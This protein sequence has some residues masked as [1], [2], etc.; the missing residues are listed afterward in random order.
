MSDAPS[1]RLVLAAAPVEYELV[2]G[3]LDH[4]HG[5]GQLLQVDEPAPVHIGRRQEGRGRPAGAVGGV[6]P[7]DAA[8]I[9]GIEQQG[10]DV[11]VLAARIGGD[12][13]G[14]PGLGASGRP[15]DDGRLAGL[16]QQGQGPGELARAQ[17]IVGG[18][19]GGIGHGSLR[20]KGS[21]GAD[22]PSGARSSPDTQP[23]P[24]SWWRQA[25][26]KGCDP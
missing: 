26:L 5:R 7:W 16:D 24:A 11:D 15:P 4:G 17:G 22:T 6:A 13:L 14:D 20:T 21:R 25:R 2:Q 9:D 12:L 10:A 3:R 1:G 18:D 23:D 19:G 8:Q